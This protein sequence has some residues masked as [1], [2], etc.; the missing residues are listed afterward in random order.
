MELQGGESDYAKEKLWLVGR[1]V[2]STVMNQFF[3]QATHY[4]YNVRNI[5][6]NYRKNSSSGW[7]GPSARL[8]DIDGASNTLLLADTVRRQEYY[9]SN[10][11]YGA[12]N[13]YDQFGTSGARGGLHAR[14]NE[15]LNI[16]W[17]DGH[18]SNHNADLFNPYEALGEWSSSSKNIWSR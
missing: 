9:S 11:L 6:S 14:H 10:E 15:S 4:G 12:Y 5:G 18:A 16:Q 7:T 3:W 2:D 1:P 13:L 17:A 8:E